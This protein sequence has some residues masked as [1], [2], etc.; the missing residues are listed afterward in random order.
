MIPEN[1]EEW[2]TIYIGCNHKGEENK[3]LSEKEDLYD[4]T[5]EHCP[6]SLPIET[7]KNILRKALSNLNEE[8]TKE[9]KKRRFVYDLFTDKLGGYRPERI[10]VDKSV[11]DH[12][13][14]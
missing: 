14:E 10:H 1:S 3:E 11:S 7:S 9:F 4:I 2:K 13:E 5:K 8:D 12:E 6:K